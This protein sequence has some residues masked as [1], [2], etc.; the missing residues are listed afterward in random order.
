MTL[1]SSGQLSISQV[2]QEIGQS[3]S[4]SSSLSFLNNLIVSGQRPAQPNM[5]GFY[6]KAYYQRNMDGNCN[7]GNCGTASSSGNK[8]CQNC[9]LS[10]LSN[11]TNCDSQQWLQSDCNCACTYNCT[12]NSNQSYNCD[13]DCACNCFWSDPELKTN[14]QPILN[15]MEILRSLSGFFYEGNQT[16]KNLG[17]DIKRTVGLDANQIEKNLP[18]ALGPYMGNYKTVKYER[19]IPVLIE[20]VKS[21]EQQINLKNHN[22]QG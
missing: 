5:A 14:M 7:N 15:P 12:Q 2:N 18:E 9:T 3:A 20:A 8:Q 17:L 10:A 4:Y 6:S 11:C 22:N 21:L 19:L 16:A 13:C 1:P